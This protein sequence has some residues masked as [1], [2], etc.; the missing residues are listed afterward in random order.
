MNV[1][2]IPATVHLSGC[3]VPSASPRRHDSEVEQTSTW[4]R[5]RE[6]ARCV[7]L[8]FLLRTPGSSDHTQTAAR[9]P[10]RRRCG[11]FPVCPPT[12]GGSFVVD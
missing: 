6:R 2:R 7:E 5:G 1:H 8:R 12:G 9:G 10:C 11:E 3:W 4:N